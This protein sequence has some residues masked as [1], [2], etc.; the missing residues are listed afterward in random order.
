M[1]LTF[2]TA[3]TAGALLYT[4]VMGLIGTVITNIPNVS[5]EQLVLDSVHI[6][7]TCIT[8]TV[9]NTGNAEV[10]T[11]NY[12]YINNVP[13]T[14]SPSVQVLPGSTATVYITGTYTRG[15][16]YNIRLVCTSGYTI[17]F[18]VAYE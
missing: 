15:N 5:T 1:L 16:T 17:S 8:A 4:Y 14:L 11:I 13:Y 18:D 2:L 7:N 3:V 6:N 9:K 10:L 12:A